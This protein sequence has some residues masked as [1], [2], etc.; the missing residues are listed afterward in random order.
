[1]YATLRDQPDDDIPLPSASVPTSERRATVRQPLS[2]SSLR[3]RR[4]ET[5]LGSEG[6]SR[7]SVVQAAT[8]TSKTVI[9]TRICLKSVA[10][11]KLQVAILARSSRE[12]SQTE[13]IV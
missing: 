7:T 5:T 13:R 3:R 6:R 11:R 4:S 8:E 10:V 12:M 9:Y 1:M 2:R